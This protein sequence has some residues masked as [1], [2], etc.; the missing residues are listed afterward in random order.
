MFIVFEGVEGC[1]KSYQSRVLRDKLLQR[2]LPV[3]LTYE[4]GGTGLGD[5]IRSILKNR[6]E[7]NMTPLTELFLISACRAQHVN[8]VIFPALQSDK[9]VVCDRFTGSTVAYQ[10]YGR[11]LEL[12]TVKRINQVSSYGLEPDIT[13][14]LDLP[15][16]KGLSR[17]HSVA[18]DRF[19]AE[20]VAFHKSIRNGYLEIARNDQKWMTIDAR[21]SRKVISDIIWSRI[22]SLLKIDR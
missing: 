11:G 17:K 5:R 9:I 8:D 21:E 22:N 19:E 7:S 12:D 2:G 10:G 20:D 13:I 14:L 1:G 6:Q 3:I 16:E 4:P 15:V 18:N